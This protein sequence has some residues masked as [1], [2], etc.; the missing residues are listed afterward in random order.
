MCKYLNTCGLVLPKNISNEENVKID[1]NK[2]Y[3]NNTWFNI[4]F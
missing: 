1:K 3:Y 2:Y 4:L